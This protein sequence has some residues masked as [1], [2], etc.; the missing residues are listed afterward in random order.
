M[1]YG[2]DITNSSIHFYTCTDKLDQRLLGSYSHEVR[3]LKKSQMAARKWVWAYCKEGVRSISP[4]W[5]CDERGTPQDAQIHAANRVARLL[6]MTRVE[7][8]R[9]D[10]GGYT[11]NGL[12][13]AM[14]K[15]RRNATVCHFLEVSIYVR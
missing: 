6:T 5:I 7:P 8:A 1:K 4:K 13:L 3:P 14:I 15:I 12:A 10:R 9:R 11:P 2:T